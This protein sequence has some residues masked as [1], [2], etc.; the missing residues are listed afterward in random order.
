MTRRLVP[1]E[2]GPRRLCQVLMDVPD[3]VLPA[4]VE[5]AARITMATLD[6]MLAD[7]CWHCA[8][9]LGGALGAPILPGFA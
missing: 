1:L 9:L 4:V 7:R 3:G 6:V 5:S 2:V 8:S